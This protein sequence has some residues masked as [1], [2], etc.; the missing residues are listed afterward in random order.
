MILIY[1]LNVDYTQILLNLVS[2]QN[3]FFV[4]FIHMKTFKNPSNGYLINDS[5]IFGV[6][7]FVVTPTKRE[8]YLSSIDQPKLTNKYTWKVDE[9]SIRFTEDEL[10]IEFTE[11]ELWYESDDFT[12]GDYKWYE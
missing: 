4:D 2:T 1:L 9:L 6:E 5:C 8:E 10:S 3:V 12:T 11:D 7:V